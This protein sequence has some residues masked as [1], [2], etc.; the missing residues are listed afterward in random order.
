[1]AKELK[2][3]VEMIVEMLQADFYS[4]LKAGKYIE[5]TLIVSFCFSFAHVVTFLLY[6][7]FIRYY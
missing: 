3:T 2:E 7:C 6:S 1:M 5:C 4:H